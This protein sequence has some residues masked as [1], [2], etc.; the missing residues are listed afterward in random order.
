MERLTS[1]AHP[2]EVVFALGALHVITSAVLL[3][4]HLALG[5]LQRQQS[6]TQRLQPQL[7]HRLA[8]RL[9]TV[10]SLVTLSFRLS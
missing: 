2:A 5:T 3:N 8:Y 1:K 6:P 4:T 9:Y 7:K 10:A